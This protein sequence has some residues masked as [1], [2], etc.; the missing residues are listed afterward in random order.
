M[1]WDAKKLLIWKVYSDD[2]SI[3][4]VDQTS[5]LVLGENPGIVRINVMSDDIPELWG[6]ALVRVDCDMEGAYIDVST[7]ELEIEKG[8]TEQIV[9]TPVGPDCFKNLIWESNDESVATVDQ[10][11]NVTGVDEGMTQIVVRNEILSSDWPEIKKVI[12]VTVGFRERVEIQP[13]MAEIDIGEP[14]LYLLVRVVDSGGVPIPDAVVHWWIEPEGQDII[15]FDETTQLV[16]ALKEGGPVEIWAEY[17]TVS[18]KA[19]IMVEEPGQSIEGAYRFNWTYT[20]SKTNVSNPWISLTCFY[21]TCPSCF[22]YSDFDSTEEYWLKIN[23]TARIEIWYDEFEGRY[24]ALADPESVQV[25]GMKR[26]VRNLSDYDHCCRYENYNCPCFS[27]PEWCDDDQE[28]C[29]C[30]SSPGTEQCRNIVRTVQYLI[31]RDQILN[32]A[33]ASDAVQ[34][35]IDGAFILDETLPK[36]LRIY[37]NPLLRINFIEGENCFESCSETPP[38]GEYCTNDDHRAP[39]ESQIDQLGVRCIDYPTCYIGNYGELYNPYPGLDLNIGE[40]LDVIGSTAN[41]VGYE[42]VLQMVRE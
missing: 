8:K 4:T 10:D 9:A 36:D 22:S 34:E 14:P 42:W 40:Q 16:T 35:K 5:G 15:A 29:F 41:G 21:W 2:E 6:V 23:G 11:G 27:Q 28:I 26:I 38:M 13:S 20:A 33:E 31:Q 17:E 18:E 7:T 32:S 19:V 30:G 3:A 39:P 24:H 1:L 37:T 12:T 25:S